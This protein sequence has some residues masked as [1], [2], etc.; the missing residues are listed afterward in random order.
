MHAGADR[1]AGDAAEP[2]HHRLLIGSHEVDAEQQPHRGY[3][4]QDGAPDRKPRRNPA[5]QV[6]M[7]MIVTVATVPVIVKVIM[8]VPVHGV[9]VI[10]LVAVVSARPRRLIA[11]ALHHGCPFSS[12]RSS[13]ES[14]DRMIVVFSSST[15]LYDSSVR[16]K[17]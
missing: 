3:R 5:A 10:V 14:D 9:A 12:N 11:I 4:E 6:L 7:D 15:F 2:Q 13:S 8:V 16:T 1:R 17:R